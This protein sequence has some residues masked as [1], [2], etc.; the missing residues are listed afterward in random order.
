MSFLR[1]ISG[2]LVKKKKKRKKNDIQM[3]YTL[4]VL[5]VPYFL[6]SSPLHLQSVN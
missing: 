5:H 4:N 1:D 6:N 3:Y 2:F